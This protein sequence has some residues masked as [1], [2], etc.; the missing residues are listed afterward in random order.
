V[1]VAPSEIYTDDGRRL[2]CNPLMEKLYELWCEMVD[3]VGRVDATVVNGDS[4]DGPDTKAKGIGVWSTNLY[5]QVN[6]AADLLKMI[7]CNKF[8][9]T[10]GSNYH[11]ETNMSCD[12]LLMEKVGGTWNIN[13]EIDCDN[14]KFHFRHKMGY[15][16]NPQSRPGKL[17]GE[18]IDAER[19]REIRGHYDII[20]RHHIHRYGVSGGSSLVDGRDEWE[21][22]GPGWKWMDDFI[23]T[24]SMDYPD[25]GYVLFYVDGSEVTWEQHV[26]QIDEDITTS[27]CVL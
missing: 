12:K 3:A 25:V 19:H 7:H 26:C 2:I 24:G 9:G 14:I 16:K 27:K 20:G 22:S 18:R 5:E 11:V 6:N 1:G 4:V 23:S 21:I 8:I 17:K 15:S 10:Q 13:Q